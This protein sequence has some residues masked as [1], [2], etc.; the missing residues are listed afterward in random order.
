[1][2]ISMNWFTSKNIE[3]HSSTSP[4]VR[5]MF[6]LSEMQELLGE[7]AALKKVVHTMPYLFGHSR[8][9]KPVECDRLMAALLQTRSAMQKLI[10]MIR[11]AEKSASAPGSCNYQ[12]LM[13]LHFSVEEIA[14]S[15]ELAEQL[16]SVCYRESS[17]SAPVLSK[18]QDQLSKLLRENEKIEDQL[19]SELDKLLMAV[20]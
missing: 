7:V 3:S 16:R 9:I 17:E 4:Q 8:A 13:R 14:T 19:E 5:L 10:V 11:R 2:S 6:A 12:L 18:L 1:M 20:S 15:L